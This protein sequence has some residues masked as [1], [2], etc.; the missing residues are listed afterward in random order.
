M[1]TFRRPFL[2]EVLAL[3]ASGPAFGA[4]HT[5]TITGT[6]FVPRNMTITAGDTIVWV[7]VGFHSVTGNSAAEPFCGSTIFSASTVS[8][9]ATFN[10]PGTYN[11]YCVPHAFE[12]N[13]RGS[14]TV[15][16]V[17]AATTNTWTGADPSGYWSAP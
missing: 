1:K 11:Y 8:C 15:Q 9:S 4:I 10:V 16:P 13:M 2:F 12:F 7:N 3:L 14:V 6:S 5:N 17:P